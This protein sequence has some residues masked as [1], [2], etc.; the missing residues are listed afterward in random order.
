MPKSA[1]RCQ[2]IREQTKETILQKS[3]LYFAKNGFTGTK[4][5][6]LA[7]HIGIGQG[8]LYTY[9]ESK[10]AL[11]Q[12]ICEKVN[13]EDIT[14][15][16]KELSS[17]PLSAKQK[18]IILS[19]ILLQQLN[20]DD[21]FAGVVALNTQM[22]FEQDSSN[23]SNRTTYQSEVYRYTAKI[24]EQGQREASVVPGTPLKLADYFW[25]VVYLYALKKLFTTKYEMIT[26]EDLQR[27]VLIP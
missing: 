11:F 15:Q 13:R 2:E 21:E 7:K 18:I 6:D 5:S 8:S 20:D 14:E 12:E 3:I 22:L 23:S 4:V 1:Q 27:T 19:N 9:F 26:P 24:I 10:E 17:L 25:G 16:I